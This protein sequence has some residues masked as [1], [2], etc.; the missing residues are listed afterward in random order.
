MG[1]CFTPCSRIQQHLILT[2]DYRVLKG[3]GNQAVSRLPS[4]MNVVLGNR[5]QHKAVVS[6]TLILL[7]S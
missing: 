4:H 5:R 3:S 7:N 1:L 6:K 2:Y